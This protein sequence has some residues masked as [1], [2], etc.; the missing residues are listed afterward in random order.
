MVAV[1][2]ISLSSRYSTHQVQGRWNILVTLYRQIVQHNSHAVNKSH[3]I[4]MAYQEAMEAVYKY[5]PLNNTKTDKT[6]TEEIQ[7]E[8]RLPRQDMIIKKSIEVPAR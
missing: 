2:H 3:P 8:S 7:E 5:I 4:T 1:Y 6:Q